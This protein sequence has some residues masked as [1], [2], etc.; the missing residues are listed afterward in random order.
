MADTSVPTLLERRRIEGEIIKPVYR[1]LVRDFGRQTADRII[2]EA[3]VQIAHEAGQKE[4]AKVSGQA[5]LESFAKILPMWS[6]GGALE[7]KNIDVG[8]NHLNY[9][10]THCQYAKMYCELG[11]AELGF[12]LS[13]RRDEAFMK[14]Y[15][16]QVELTRTTTIMT[17]GS[18]CDFRYQLIKKEALTKVPLPSDD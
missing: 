2:G 4:A 6:R 5:D 1:L 3:I 9:D 7:I 10:V 11:L 18:R 13:C 12:I 8:P 17:G 15:A 16:P 14:G